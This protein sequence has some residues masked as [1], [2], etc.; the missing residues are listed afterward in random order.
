MSVKSGLATFFQVLK[1]FLNWPFAGCHLKQCFRDMLTITVH[2]IVPISLF[3][4]FWNESAYAFFLLTFLFPLKLTQ[5]LCNL[6]NMDI[7]H[8]RRHYHMVRFL[9]IENSMMIDRRFFKK[10]GPLSQINSSFVKSHLILHFY[11]EMV[12]SWSI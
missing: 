7:V 8:F 4:N 11:L 3:V 1:C 5:R 2:N 6:S 10:S 12:R 9:T